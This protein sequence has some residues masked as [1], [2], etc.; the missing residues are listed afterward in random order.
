MSRFEL[1]STGDICVSPSQPAT[2][3]PTRI[4]GFTGRIRLIG[5]KAYDSDRLDEALLQQYGTEM[6]APN[7]CNRRVA[8]N[9]VD[10]SGSVLT[11]S[12]GLRREPSRGRK[13]WSLRL[14]S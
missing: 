4:A 5:D 3:N 2:L 7:K 12:R 6:I 9:D 10:S 1:R 14:P 13:T 11:I 8:M